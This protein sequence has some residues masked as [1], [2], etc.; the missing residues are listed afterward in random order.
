MR[1]ITAKPPRRPKGVIV[2]A[3]LVIVFGLGEIWV[4]LFGNYLGILSKSMHPSVA[5]GIVGAFY[6]LAGVALL[7]TRRAWGTFLSLFFIGAEVLGRVYLVAI[8][9]AP[10]HGADLCK[11]VIGGIIAIGFMAYIG[12]HSVSKDR[13]GS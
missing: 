13:S 12:L 8:G 2:V 6:S 3:I 9:V 10:S 4:G 11:I 1:E 7:I 5:T